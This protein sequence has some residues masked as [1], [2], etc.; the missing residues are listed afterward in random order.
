M[1]TFLEFIIF[2]FFYPYYFLSYMLWFMHFIDKYNCHYRQTM[3]GKWS[4]ITDYHCVYLTKMTTTVQHS[5]HT[6]LPT[7]YNYTPTIHWIGS[8][9]DSLGGKPSDL[10]MLWSQYQCRIPREGHLKINL[11]VYSPMIIMEPLMNPCKMHVS[12][13]TPAHPPAFMGLNIHYIHWNASNYR[14]PC[15]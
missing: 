13:L 9:N 7:Q 8:H 14:V 12:S 1:L 5:E 6:P 10:I 2:C 4:I 15:H 3:K 11:M